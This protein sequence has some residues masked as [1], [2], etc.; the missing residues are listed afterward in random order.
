MELLPAGVCKGAALDAVAAHYGITA[1]RVV[2]FGDGK[3]D[4]ELLERAGLG[5][6]MGNAHPELAA[7]ADVVIG[8]HDTD[9]ISDFLR[10]RFEAR[11]GRLVP[12][13]H[14]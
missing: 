12:R 1:E 10:G 13:Q 5:V 6:A 11:G 9:A 14:R 2:A 7:V 4:I 8:H 3:N